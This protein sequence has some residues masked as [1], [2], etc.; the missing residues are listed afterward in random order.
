MP[1]DNSWDRMRMDTVGTYRTVLSQPLPVGTHE[2]HENPHSLTRFEPGIT[3]T[4]VEP[5]L[6]VPSLRH[7]PIGLPG[8]KKYAKY[9]PSGVEQGAKSAL[10]SGLLCPENCSVQSIGKLLGRL[11]PQWNLAITANYFTGWDILF[12]LG[13]ILQSG[14][15]Y[16]SLWNKWCRPLY[17]EESHVNGRLEGLTAASPVAMH[18]IAMSG[19]RVQLITPC[20]SNLMHCNRVCV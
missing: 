13:W 18:T 17:S 11:R 12:T 10:G 19:F 6:L 4:K 16:R 15:R 8:K 1:V 9:P 7:V 3:R 5:E 14:A 2:D 20:A